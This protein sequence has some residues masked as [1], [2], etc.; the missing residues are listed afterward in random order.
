MSAPFQ[1]YRFLNSDGS[2]KVWGVRFNGGGSFTSI[3][4][5]EGAKMSSKTKGITHPDDVQKLIRSKQRKGYEYLGGSFY[6]GDDGKV[7]TSPPVVNLEPDFPLENPQIY[8][9]LKYIKNLPSE[10]FNSFKELG[11]RLKAIFSRHGKNF[12]QDPIR[13]SSLIKNSGIINKEDGVFV[14]LF[15]LALKKLAPFGVTVS[16]SHED[17]LE[18][19]DQLK[20]ETEALSFFDTDL[21]SIRSIA[22]EIGLLQKRLDLSTIAPEIEGYYF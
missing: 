11:G 1:L 17:G 3:W 5:K 7:V 22:E 13:K 4:G 6:R 9:S 2:A 10:N 16:L 12:D 18:I 19:S 14:F 8:W 15:L 20:L 21:E